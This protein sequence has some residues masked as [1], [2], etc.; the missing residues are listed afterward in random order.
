MVQRMTA[1]RWLVALCAASTTCFLAC[2]GFAAA[3]YPGGTWFDRRAS[4]HSLLRNFLCD[5][6]Q[7]RALNGQ[8]AEAGSLAARG[9]MAVMMVAI[10]A[11]FALIAGLAPPG[12]RA[13]RVTWRA[14]LAASVL[15]CAVPLL[16][17]D[18]ARDAHVI[19]V[20]CAFAP[21]LAATLAAFSVCL[22]SPRVPRWLVALAAFTLAMGA[23]DGIGYAYAYAL[24]FA[25]V[26]VAHGRWL[27]L[28]LPALQRAATFGLLAWIAAVCL[29]AWRE[30]G[31]PRPEALTTGAVP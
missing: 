25:N 6:M 10:G 3:S 30:E 22:R 29:H 15:G 21:A 9:G 5:L 11:F 20:V 16:P 17:S 13:G 19:A 26:R 14:G 24:H 23:L 28:A 12:S 8:E 27:N 1:R 2:F 7:T 18:L 31:A 4:G